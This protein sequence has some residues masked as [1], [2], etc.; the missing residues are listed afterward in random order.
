MQSDNFLVRHLRAVSIFLVLGAILSVFR[1]LSDPFTSSLTAILPVENKALADHYAFLDAFDA[2]DQLVIDLSAINADTH[3]E[4][5]A[6][7]ASIAD[8]L[9]NSG[10]FNMRTGMDLHDYKLLQDFLITSWPVLFTPKDSVWLSNRLFRDTLATRFS[11]SLKGLFVF[12]D[13][14]M[15]AA[16]LQSD[17]FGFRWRILQKLSA[18][19]PDDEMYIQDGF[20]TNASR[21]RILL[22]AESK[23]PSMESPTAQRITRTMQKAADRA[24]ASGYKLHWIAAARASLDNERMIKRDVH[25]TAPFVFAFIVALCTLIYRK[26]RYGVLVFFPTVLGILYS[27]A[28]FSLFHKPSIIMLGFSAALLGI[29]VDY[30]IHFFHFI[31]SKPGIDSPQRILRRPIWASALT[32]SGAFA[33]LAFGGMP[34]LSQLGLMTALG[35]MV[36]AFLSVEI[37]PLFFRP[38]HTSRK[39]LVNLESVFRRLYKTQVSLFVAA[40]VGILS[41]L[42]WTRVPSITFDGDP[43][44][45]NGMSTEARKDEQII[46][47]Q[48][49]AV[50][51][52]TYLAV[53]DSTLQGVLEAMEFRL[54][55]LL[56]TLVSGKHVSAGGM[57]TAVFPSRQVQEENLQRWQLIWDS[58]KLQ[59]L[60]AVIDSVCRHFRVSA[61]PFAGYA[62]SLSS[63]VDPKITYDDLPNGFRETLLGTVLRESGNGWYGSVPVIQRS[64]WDRIDR[65]ARKHDVLAVNESTLGLRLVQII[66]DGFRTTSVLI[67]LVV[68]LVLAIML[69]KAAYIAAALISVALST[70]LTLG[71]MTVLGI[72]LNLVSLMVLAFVFGLGIDYAVVIIHL[73][74]AENAGTKSFAAPAAS[75]TIA[76]L[77]TLAGLGVLLFAQHPVLRTLGATGFLGITASYLVAIFVTPSVLNYVG[78]SPGKKNSPGS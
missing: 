75:I 67:P 57:F 69:R 76:A 33:A 32:T 35:L 21:S 23:Q 11:E 41:I 22:L 65:S 66:R 62:D 59:I 44:S 43:D 52:G 12:S 55:P 2:T 5:S 14:A 48:W 46:S 68:A 74:I 38:H 7:A 63:P 3:T 40:V 24:R 16:S 50:A 77:T 10:L 64:S 61:A 45:L 54:A 9:Q 18:F 26:R 6:V 49:E 42:L 13:K 70:G 4:I 60:N 31:D 39:P 56:D 17:P 58:E 47:Q 19:R 36:V 73:G 1:L 72:P 34:G 27:L 29:T 37:L 15:D 53:H 78:I 51:S 30:A 71:G 20:I 28:L 8:T 25:R